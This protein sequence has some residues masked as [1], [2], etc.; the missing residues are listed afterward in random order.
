[1]ENTTLPEYAALILRLALGTMLW[2]HAA[3]KFFT[4]TLAG[5]AG[6]FESL[7]LPGFLAYVTFFTE[8]AAG[9][10][11]ITGFHARWAAAAA[12]PILASTIIFVHGANGWLFSNQGGGWEYP[13]FLI[14]AS[15]VQVLLGDGAFALR[16]AFHKSEPGEN[17]SPRQ[18]FVHHTA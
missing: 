14:T 7:G 9:A 1:M 15:V 2:S 16:R 11:L 12:I 8:L 6:Y 17:H 5:T 18:R 10:M 3:L 13:A 4:F